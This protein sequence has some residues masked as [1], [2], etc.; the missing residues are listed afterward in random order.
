MANKDIEFNYGLQ[1]KA[2]HSKLLKDNKKEEI[3]TVTDSKK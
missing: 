1:I 3:I 2:I